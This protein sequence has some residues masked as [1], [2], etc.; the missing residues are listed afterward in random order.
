MRIRMPIMV[1][2]SGLQVRIRNGLRAENHNHTISSTVLHDCYR[3]MSE[4][5]SSV[6]LDI[7]D[8]KF[9]F[10]FLKAC[11]W[12]GHLVRNFKDKDCVRRP[13]ELSSFSIVWAARN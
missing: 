12:A 1:L 10:G 11:G 8:E 13:R 2:L 9:G 5:T 6:T 4:I 3:F 7:S